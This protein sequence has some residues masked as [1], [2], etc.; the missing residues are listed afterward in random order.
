MENWVK[1]YRSFCFVAFLLSGCVGSVNNLNPFS[2]VAKNNKSIV[3]PAVSSVDVSFDR[4]TITGSHLDKVTGMTVTGWGNNHALTISSQTTSSVVGLVTSPS[5]RFYAQ[6]TYELIVS[7]ASGQII[8]P[9]NFQLLDLT[10]TTNKLQNSSVTTDKIASKAVTYAKIDTTSAD[11]GDVLTYSSADGSWLAAP[12]GGGGGGGGVT[13]ITR[14]SGLLYKNTNLTSTGT[15]AV[16]IGSGSGQ[17]PT[18]NGS[19]DFSFNNSIILDA[20]TTNEGT[21][22]LLDS[23]DT[24]DFLLFNDVGTF[25]LQY[26]G[27]A[28][29]PYSDALTINVATGLTTLPQDVVVG[30]TLKINNNG[31]AASVI[32]F[33]RCSWRRRANPG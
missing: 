6:Q 11:D 7:S 10:V 20:A 5:L 28:A 32:T 15:I 31:G 30:D 22:S 23:N 16:D 19:G 8:Y 2:D 25:R 26:S 13:S 33:P 18:L 17:I 9:V 3:T 27:T 14:G 12:S 29:P 1:S 21:L 4:V 24:S